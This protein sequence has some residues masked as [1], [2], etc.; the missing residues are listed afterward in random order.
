M[1]TPESAASPSLPIKMSMAF[2]GCGFPLWGK[3]GERSGPVAGM[4]GMHGCVGRMH[5]EAEAS[6]P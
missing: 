1:I 6:C 4:G 2:D 5:A 3:S